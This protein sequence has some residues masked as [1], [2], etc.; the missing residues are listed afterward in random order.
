MIEQYI[1][2]DILEEL[3]KLPLAAGITFLYILIDVLWHIRQKKKTTDSI[4]QTQNRQTAEKTEQHDGSRG[5][6]SDKDSRRKR[7][8]HLL[9][10]AC[11]VLYFVFLLD[12]VFFCREAGSRV[13]TDMTLFGTWGTTARDHAYVLENVLLFIPYGVLFPFMIPEKRFW[14]TP[15]AGCLTSICIELIQLVTSCGYCQL[16]DM[17][18]NTAGTVLGF[19][20]CIFLRK[21]FHKNM[22]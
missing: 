16:D 14:I 15:A 21:I 20:V 5:N 4:V 11:F 1:M 3:S 18:M 9:F 13:G 6:D 2:P 8:F 12:L 10:R 17:V 7:A 19:L 22:K